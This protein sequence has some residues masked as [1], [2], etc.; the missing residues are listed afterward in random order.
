MRFYLVVQSM[1]QLKQKYGHE[2]QTIKGNCENWVFLSSKEVE[3]LEE[4]STLCGSLRTAREGGGQWPLI[5]PS[6]LQ[7]LSKQRGEALI[8]CGRSYPFISE[9]ADIDAYAFGRFPPHPMAEVDI[10]GV[11]SVDPQKMFTEILLNQRTMPYSKAENVGPA[12]VEKPEG[13]TACGAPS[14][15]PGL[16]I[17]E[18]WALDDSR[19]EGK[20]RR[21]MGNYDIL[22]NDEGEIMIVLPIALDTEPE[23]P[24]FYYDGG[25]H[26]IL[27]ADGLADMIICDHI[28][29]NIREDMAGCTAVLFTTQPPGGEDETGVVEFMAAVQIQPGLKRLA[30]SMLAMAED[31]EQPEE[32]LD[33]IW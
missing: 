18:A 30:E 14:E 26:G 8:F 28:H 17:D 31:L 6:Q 2:T 13:V 5:S 11:V 23:N 7:R 16:E 24:V 29:P 21:P 27:V 4:I 32:E 25:P 33:E 1:H 3:L 9:M 19:I 10:E 15:A 12:A 22:Q 20:R